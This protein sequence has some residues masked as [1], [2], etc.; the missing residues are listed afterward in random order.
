LSPGIVAIF[1]AAW[2]PP[3][4]MRCARATETLALV[5]STL[6]TGLLDWSHSVGL[7]LAHIPPAFDVR[8]RL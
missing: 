7:A 6:D 4:S 8:G 3:A 5:R 1:S 2:Q